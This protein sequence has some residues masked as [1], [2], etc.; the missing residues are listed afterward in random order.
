MLVLTEKSPA[1]LCQAAKCLQAQE[2]TFR[3]LLD[4]PENMPFGLQV[5]DHRL[6]PVEII[7]LHR[8]LSHNPEWL[9]EFVKDF[10]NDP[11]VPELVI[12]A[13]FVSPSEMKHVKTLLEIISAGSDREEGG[14]PVRSYWYCSRYN[15]QLRPTIAPYAHINVREMENSNTDSTATPAETL[16]EADNALCAHACSTIDDRDALRRIVIDL[17]TNKTK[18]RYKNA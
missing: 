5:L 16:R 2:E 10:L 9:F 15:E 1:A 7:D 13:D 11:A 4:L 14:R 6:L 12:I 8:A 18:S 17:A 3:A